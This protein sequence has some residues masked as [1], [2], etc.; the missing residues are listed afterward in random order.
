MTKMTI[1]K[2]E[3]NFLGVLNKTGAVLPSKTV[4]FITSSSTED[5]LKKYIFNKL[6]F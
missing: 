4:V 2:M 5:A 6:T 1:I 3:R